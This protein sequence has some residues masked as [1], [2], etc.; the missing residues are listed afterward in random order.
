MTGIKKCD[1]VTVTVTVTV[2]HVIDWL[3][4]CHIVAVTLFCLTVTL[5]RL[6]DEPYFT[7]YFTPYMTCIRLAIYLRRI[8]R[9]IDGSY[10]LHRIY[11]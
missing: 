10:I 1:S 7:P 3:P 8:V 6:M 11:V 5:L 2:L 4:H 9:V